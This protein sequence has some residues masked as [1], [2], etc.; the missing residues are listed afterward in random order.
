MIE[1]IHN[2]GIWTNLCGQIY[3]K[4]LKSYV[5]LTISQEMQLLKTD[6]KTLESMNISINLK[7]WRD[8][9]Y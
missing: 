5:T 3:S 8:G 1:T 7:P 6:I 4:E 9:C 2:K